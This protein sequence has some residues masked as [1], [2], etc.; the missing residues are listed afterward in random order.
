[1]HDVTW[2]PDARLNQNVCM[3]T[4]LWSVTVPL[5]FCAAF[6]STSSCLHLEDRTDS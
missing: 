3:N 4:R 2:T 6:C 1:M 5:G